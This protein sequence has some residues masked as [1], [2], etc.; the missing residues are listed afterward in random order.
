MPMPKPKDGAAA[1]V[2]APEDA[3]NRAGGAPPPALKDGRAE[4]EDDG[5]GTDGK[6]PNE[7][8]GVVAGMTPTL[9]LAVA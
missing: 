1:V 2:A 3:P 8:A 4:D 9:V 5:A 6:P 7:G